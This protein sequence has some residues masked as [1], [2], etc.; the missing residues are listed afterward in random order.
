MIIKPGD[1]SRPGVEVVAE[2]NDAELQK[3]T[4]DVADIT[5][6]STALIQ[7]TPIEGKPG[8]FSVTIR[9]DKEIDGNLLLGSLK[10]GMLREWGWG[11]KF[12][13]RA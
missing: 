5:I 10:D 1:M 7:Q 6:S 11:D 9:V 8:W 13:L 2:L 4:Q 3:L 12:K